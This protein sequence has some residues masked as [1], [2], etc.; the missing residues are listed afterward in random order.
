M[1]KGKQSVHPAPGIS[2]GFG[3]IIEEGLI[4]GFSILALLVIISIVLSI[5]NWSEGLVDDLL[6]NFGG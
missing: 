3:P 1:R 6:D 4:I 5:L 2:I